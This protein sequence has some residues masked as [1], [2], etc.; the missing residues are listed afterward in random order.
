MES[1]SQIFHPFGS[2]R[3]GTFAKNA[4]RMGHSLRVNSGHA[5]FCLTCYSGYWGGYHLLL[6]QVF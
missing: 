5:D 6:F 2:R 1:K 3:V 4:T